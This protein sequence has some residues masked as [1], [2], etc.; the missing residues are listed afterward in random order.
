[1]KSSKFWDIVERL[2]DNVEIGLWAT[3]LAGVVFLVVFVIPALPTIRSQ[4]QRV[5]AQQIADENSFFCRKLNKK[6]GTP[7]YDECLL[8]LGDFRLKVEQRIY[9]ES[10]F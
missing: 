4:Y 2:Y 1:M 10:A 3:L 7:A 8:V 5:R 6:V 9:D